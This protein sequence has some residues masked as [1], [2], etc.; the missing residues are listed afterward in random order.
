M[1]SNKLITK[2]IA[3]ICTGVI[4]LP[5][6]GVGTGNH[7]RAAEKPREYIIQAENDRAYEKITEQYEE[8]II[9]EQKEE[10]ILEDANITV[11]ELTARQAKTL[12]EKKGVTIEPNIMLDGGS[13]D[14]ANKKEASIRKDIQRLAK[15]KWN[16]SAIAAETAKSKVRGKKINIAI[17]DSGIDALIDIPFENQVSL[18][19]EEGT[20]DAT[21]HGTIMSNLIYNN[22]NG[23]CQ[24]G[25]LPK[26]NSVGLHNL[27]I[28]DEKNQAPLSRAIEGLQW[29]IDHDIQIVNMSFGTEA[30]SDILRDMIQKAKKAGILMVSSVG[31]SGE[32]NEALLNI[33]PVIRKL[34]A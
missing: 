3:V 12:E 33:L 30:Q 13:R 16:I 20:D 11:A 7:A 29:C 17:L 6:P 8:E 2:L 34:S 25:I 9:E 23:S 15:Q 27:R 10:T 19:P 1:K 22:K 21:G 4:M 24:A 28:L 31:N 26:N 18:I 14:S 32:K 5:S